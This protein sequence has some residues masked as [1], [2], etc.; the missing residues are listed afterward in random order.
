[1]TECLMK[2]SNLE[3]ELLPMVPTDT[4]ARLVERVEN[5]R[6]PLEAYQ[7]L[8]I[9]AAWAKTRAD[10]KFAE[11]LEAVAAW[12]RSKAQELDWVLAQRSKKEAEL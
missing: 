11:A 10:G 12:A 5:V 4:L 6:V 2:L 3:S 7:R 8:S 9:L 1:M